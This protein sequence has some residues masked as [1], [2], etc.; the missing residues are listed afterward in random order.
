MKKGTVYFFTGLSGAGKTTLGTL[1]YEHLHSKKDNIVFFDGDV[2]RSTCYTKTDYS[3]EAR[4]SS[5]FEM[6]GLCNLLA[7][8][9]ID[10]VVCSISMYDDVRAWNHEHITNYKEIYVRVTMDTLYQRDQKQLYSKGTQV[11]GKD[12][13][14]DEPKCPDIIVQN[15]GACPP[16]MLVQHIEEAL[17]AHTAPGVVLGTDHPAPQIH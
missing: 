8:Q 11:V 4:R 13:P 6:F 7:E 2:L 10:V 15:D 3:T 1:F 14:Y 17:A 5:A 12:L 16:D 9:G